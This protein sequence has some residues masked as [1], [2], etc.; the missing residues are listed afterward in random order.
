MAEERFK[1]DVQPRDERGSA[2]A[3]R[4][5]KTGLVPGVIYGGRREAIA[6]AVP[7]RDLR[8]ALTG[9]HGLNAI[10]DVAVGDQGVRPAILKDYQRDVMS[11]HVAHVDF[12]EVRLDRP[13]QTHVGVELVGDSVG[14]REGGVLNQV[15]REVTVEALPMEVPDRIEVDVTE[16]GIGDSVRVGDLA[17]LPGVTFVDDP[18]ET[19]IATVTQPTVVELPEEMLEGEEPEVPAPEGDQASERAADQRADGGGDA[20]GS[21]GTVSG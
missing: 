4:M 8:R 5:R 12:Q 20:A 10:L 21:P 17:A 1:L 19:V 16:L 2:A 7:E 13:I 18:D 15:A 6:I 9:G 3:R 11:G 14:T